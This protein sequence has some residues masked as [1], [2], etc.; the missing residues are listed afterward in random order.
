[1][2][3]M[4]E[5]EGGTMFIYM[6]VGLLL[7]LLVIGFSQRGKQKRSRTT[8][9]HASPTYTDSSNSWRDDDRDDKNRFHD[10]RDDSSSD[11]G[12][13]SGNASSGDSGG[14]DGGGGGE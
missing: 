1:M 2:S 11:S 5:R 9:D 14:G 4:L 3:A 8:T 6:M 12:N 13:D 10:S 7:L